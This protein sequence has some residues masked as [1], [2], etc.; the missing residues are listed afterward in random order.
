[1]NFKIYYV[2]LS[3]FIGSI[4]QGYSQNDVGSVEQVKYAGA[5]EFGLQHS[6]NLTTLSGNNNSYKVGKNRVVEL[7]PVG[8]RLTVDLGMFTNFYFSKVVSLDFEVLYSYMGAHVNKKTTLLHDLGE[9]S[10][11]DNESYALQY[12]RFPLVLKVHPSEKAFVEFGGYAATLLSAEKFYPWYTDPGY[13]REK[14]NGISSFDAGL[15]V[16]VGFDL[17]I[18]NLGFRY[19]YGLVNVFEDQ[20]SLDLRNSMFQV[21]AQWK[22]YSDIKKQM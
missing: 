15:L 2:L 9:I 13:S 10:G 7:D 19:N 1:M 20:G 4:I 8:R 18:L 14:L 21:V 17:K 11:T 16:G 6:V 12:F 22:M 5:F 3:I